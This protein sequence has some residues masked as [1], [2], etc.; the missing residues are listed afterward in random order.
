M[1]QPHM[2]WTNQ[3]IIYI[4]ILDINI[5]IYTHT[6][7]PGQQKQ[8]NMYL[9]LFYFYFFVCLFVC[10][11]VCLCVCVFVICLTSYQWV[12]Y[13]L[14]YVHYFFHNSF[15]AHLNTSFLQ[16]RDLK[17]LLFQKSLASKYIP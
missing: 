10:V 12:L 11:F 6:Y 4:Y 5:Y 2:S 17:P 14:I 13:H 9:D 16:S 15:R 7:A 3:Y 8:V 1:A